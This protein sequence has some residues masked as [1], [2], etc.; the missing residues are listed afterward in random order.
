MT[1][2]EIEEFNATLHM[3]SIASKSRPTK[4]RQQHFNDFRFAT[5]KVDPNMSI[6][7]RNRGTGFNSFQILHADEDAAVTKNPVNAKGKSTQVRDRQAVAISSYA[8]TA[9]LTNQNSLYSGNLGAT[10][11]QNT[12]RSQR[13]DRKPQ[14]VSILS[15]NIKEIVGKAPREIQ[16]EQK[17]KYDRAIMGDEPPDSAPNSADPRYVGSL[18]S[19]SSQNSS[20]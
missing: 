8:D 6:Y 20:L 10:T 2:A 4:Q 17:Q 15:S 9:A 11:R 7:R 12:D 18:K 14:R 19:S 16:E 5:T 3:S 13:A 1:Q